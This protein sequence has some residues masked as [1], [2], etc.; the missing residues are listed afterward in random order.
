MEET[1]KNQSQDGGNHAKHINMEIND[2]SDKLEEGAIANS[3]KENE[4]LTDL[5]NSSL[6][7][8]WW[9]KKKTSIGVAENFFQRAAKDPL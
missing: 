7:R 1:P 5:A 8:P 6:T 4:K 9:K 2:Q 3:F